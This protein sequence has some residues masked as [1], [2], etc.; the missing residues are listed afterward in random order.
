MFRNVL[1]AIFFCLIPFS[2]FAAETICPGGASPRSDIAWCADFESL[3]NCTTGQ[4]ASCQSDNGINLSVADTNGFKIKSCPVTAAVG[5]GCIYGSGKASGTGAGYST[6]TFTG[7]TSA[8]MRFYTRFGVGYMQNQSSTGNH[9]PGINFSDGSNCSGYISFD[10]T[11]TT[12]RII[13]EVNNNS[14]GGHNPVTGNLTVNLGNWTPQNNHWYEI[15]MR[16]IMNTVATS[17]SISGGNGI[18]EMWVDNVKILSYTNVNIRGDSV[19]SNFNNAF[20]ARSYEGLGVPAW[21]PNIY[22]DAFAFSNDGTQIGLSADAN[23]LGTA[24]TTSPYWLAVGGDGA[25]ERKLS[26]D[27]SIPGSATK[28][29]TTG[30]S[31][32]WRDGKSYVATPDHNGYP[33]DSS[34]PSCT[35]TDSMQVQTTTSGHGAGVYHLMSRVN[36]TT[37]HTIANHGWIYLPSTNTYGTAFPYAG[38]S[39][40]CSNSPSA[41]NYGCYIGLAVSSGNWALVLKKDGVAGTAHTTSTAATTDTWHEYEVMVSDTNKCSLAIDQTW[42]IDTVTCNQAVS[43]WAFDSTSTGAQFAVTGIIDGS[44]SGTFTLNYDDT[45]IGGA[46]FWSYRGWNS[47]SSPFPV[48]TPTAT[49]TATPTPPQHNPASHLGSR[50]RGRFFSLGFL[51]L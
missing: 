25:E 8:N 7:V 40:Y 45:D 17:S 29:V 21:K 50:G 15:E 30:W 19:T 11:I 37:S 27:C 13:V 14:C 16:A 33:C 24:D 9:G 28:Y 48:P 4:E 46:S 35:T 32:D 3:A 41:N 51:G 44:P 49:P 23:S 22:F 10:P 26:S 39:R 38:F 2:A 18:V 5:S 34:C 42:L 20:L 47:A 43:T 12:P 31:I 36:T 1:F 6:K